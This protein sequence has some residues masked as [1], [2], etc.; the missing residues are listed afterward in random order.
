[1]IFDFPILIFETSL[2]QALI[3][4]EERLIVYRFG[5]RLL[6]SIYGASLSILLFF[7]LSFEFFFFGKFSFDIFLSSRPRIGCIR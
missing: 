6:S 3:V 1:M 2:I 5:T 4:I 7:V